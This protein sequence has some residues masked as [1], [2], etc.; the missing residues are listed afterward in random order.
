MIDTENFTEIVEGEG[1]PL[2][3]ELNTNAAILDISKAISQT[4]Q[5]RRYVNTNH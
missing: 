2:S 5:D 1:T 4:V 3:G